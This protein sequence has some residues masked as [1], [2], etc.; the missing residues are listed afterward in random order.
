MTFRVLKT[1][2]PILMFS[3]HPLSGLNQ[4]RMQKTWI[5]SFAQTS[6]TTLGE[7]T[8]ENSIST[9]DIFDMEQ[10][11]PSPSKNQNMKEPSV[12]DDDDSSFYSTVDE[13]TNEIEDPDKDIKSK[14]FYYLGGMGLFYVIG[15]ISSCLCKLCGK[16]NNNGTDAAGID[17]ANGADT[18]ASLPNDSIHVSMSATKSQLG[19]V[20]AAEGGATTTVNSTAVDNMAVSAA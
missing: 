1:L 11:L 6:S 4:L 2:H 18:S 7:V 17:I 3:I 12:T 5:I 19:F 9:I 20:A 14:L 13:E 16:G 10:N 15:L 8:L